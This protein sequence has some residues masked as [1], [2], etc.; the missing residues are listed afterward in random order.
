ME[1]KHLI[2]A[3]SILIISTDI[4]AQQ[5]TTINGTTFKSDG[6]LSVGTSSI[7]T[8]N[9]KVFTGGQYFRVGAWGI[10]ISDAGW[11]NTLILSNK[12]DYHEIH[13]NDNKPLILQ[14]Y[15][16][17]NIGIGTTNPL[18]RVDIKIKS[19]ESSIKHLR[20]L[21]GNEQ[22][23]T[24]GPLSSSDGG[25][26]AFSAFS[27]PSTTSA[28]TMVLSAYTN[29]LVPQ[30]N[31]QAAVS[32]RGYD[33]SDNST[34]QNM[35]IFK[36]MNGHHSAYLTVAA[37]G[38]VGLGTTSPSAE[39]EVKSTS[40]NIAEFHLNSA[41]N[42]KPSAI[43]F[44]DDGQSTWGI[45]AHYPDTDKLSIFNYHNSSNTMV[46]DSKGNVGIGTKDPKSKLAVNGQIRAT[47][48]KVLTSIN[49]VPDYV[50]EP[51]Y[52]LR[53][54]E[55]TKA[56]ITENKHLPEIPS[57]AEIG[58]NGLDLGEMNMKLLK[59]IEELTLHQIALL[60]RLEKVEAELQAQRD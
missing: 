28:P 52:V 20:F 47:E 11:R 10:G 19:D 43:R 59:K 32:I 6:R 36:V 8:D 57:A 29:D 42:N 40:N 7:G 49:S 38:K 54:L 55:E 2:V 48:V 44:Q 39:L 27:K 37:N 60:E 13:T 31:Y 4:Q 12:Y 51:E 5:D 53:T 45:L 25:G 46:F 35:P 26:L 34:L 14:N 56:F 1:M 50:F 58:E 15:A 17:G 3:I 41:A 16:G 23:G 21:D 9:L 18:G 33:V 30:L 22:I 24:F